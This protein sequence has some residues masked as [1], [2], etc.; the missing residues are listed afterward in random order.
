MKPISAQFTYRVKSYKGV[1]TNDLATWDLSFARHRLVWNK[2]ILSTIITHS[3]PIRS[4]HRRCSVR[5]DVLR[6][7][8]QNSQ[9]NTC[10]RVS[11]LKETLAQVFSCEISKNTFFTEHL[12][13][14]SSDLTSHQIKKKCFEKIIHCFLDD[15]NIN[16][17]WVKSIS[18]VTTQK[19]KFSNKN[20]FSKCDQIRSCLWIWS[21]LLKKFVM[22]NFIF[23][24]KV[25]T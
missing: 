5:K 10:T 9:E 6:N 17:K 25:F 16:F 4:S 23:C 24:A 1:G 2:F 22:E 18:A 7:F 21:H 8:S 11:F 20:F 13:A 14:T 15:W 12:R 3:R 19:M